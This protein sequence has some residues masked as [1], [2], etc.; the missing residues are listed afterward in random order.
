MG[1]WK[2]EDDRKGKAKLDDTLA[3]LRLTLKVNGGHSMNKPVSVQWST[4]PALH[5]LWRH[6]LGW[7]TMPA[8]SI[9]QNMLPGHQPQ[10][11]KWWGEGKGQI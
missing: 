11:G 7:Q 8:V 10:L 9:S 6:T 3:T 2:W 1:C 4:H 5:I